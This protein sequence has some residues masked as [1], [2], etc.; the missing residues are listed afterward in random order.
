MKMHM[1]LTAVT[2]VLL[3]LGGAALAHDRGGPWP[4]AGNHGMMPEVMRMHE[5]MMGD[6][7]PM[8]GPMS[9][10]G[11]GMMGMMGGQG[12][13]MMGMAME[14][15]DAD[16]NGTVTPDEG[17]A[18]LQAL[19]ADYDADNDE[20][21][22]LSEFET[23]HS[24]MIRETMVDR[25]QFLDDDGD[26]AVTMDEIVKPADMIGGMQQ[27]YQRMMSDGMMPGPQGGMQ[28]NGSMMGTPGMGRMDNN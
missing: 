23:L 18:G 12:M 2:A 19:L 8:P 20:A 6:D 27:M 13:G 3:G 14:R 10:M 9:G 15:F 24:A 26:G 11:P 21:L 28:G 4:G 25:F 7:G 17:R 1:K 22:S 16:G 5:Q